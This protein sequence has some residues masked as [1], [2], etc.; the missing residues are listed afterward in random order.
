MLDLNPL[1]F[2]ELL[3]VVA[4]AVGW[5][6][7]EKVANSYDREKKSDTDETGNDGT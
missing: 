1:A 7:L 4:F 5:F 3:I 2:F 6:I